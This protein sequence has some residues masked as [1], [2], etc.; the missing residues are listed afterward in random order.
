MVDQKTA[1]ASVINSTS[2]NN[3][4]LISEQSPTID[5]ASAQLP[6]L[7]LAVKATYR[8][9][10]ATSQ[11]TVI[12]SSFSLRRDALEIL[13]SEAGFQLVGKVEALRD[14]VTLVNGAAAPPA[15]ILIDVHDWKEQDLETVARMRPPGSKTRI[16]VL[17]ERLAALSIEQLRRA[18]IDGLLTPDMHKAALMRYLELVLLGERV[19]HPG[20]LAEAE[21]GAYINSLSE[22]GRPARLST[23]EQQVLSL[24]ARGMSNKQMA[25]ELEITDGT[26]KIHVRNL[27][28]KVGARN[29]TQLAAWAVSQGVGAG[30]A[31]GVS[32]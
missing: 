19:F 20:V 17:A 18:G 15:L 25:R 3:R 26:V 4:V 6:M 14:A 21:S 28:R 27:C 13:L 10:M 8:M 2:L 32:R 23:R 12:I 9:Q 31:T 16:V 24:V 11:S 1:E 22:T 29:R 7:H 30:A 5:T